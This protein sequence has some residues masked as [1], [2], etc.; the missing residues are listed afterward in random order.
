MGTTHGMVL[1]GAVQLDIT[2]VLVLQLQCS[3]CGRA[4]FGFSAS[5]HDMLL[6]DAIGQRKLS[7]VL[8]LD[9]R[10]RVVVKSAVLRAV[11]AE[12]AGWLS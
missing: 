7:S 10:R 4:A 3:L 11:L 2:I 1:C 8:V 6:N 12:Q 9:E 5:D